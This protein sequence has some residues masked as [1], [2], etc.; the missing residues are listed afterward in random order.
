METPLQVTFRNIGPSEA[1]EARIRQRADRLERH[2][3]RIVGCRVVVEE[4]HHH[5]RKGNH[6]QVHVNVTVPG[7][8][9][10]ANREPNAHHAYIDVY[11]AIRDAFDSI[12]RQLIEHARRRGEPAPS[13]VA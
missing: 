3:D 4:L 10:V 12:D 13:R 6:F 7:A 8:E 2:F 9:M 11:T 5:H 1:I